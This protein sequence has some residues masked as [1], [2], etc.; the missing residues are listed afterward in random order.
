MTLELSCICSGN[1]ARHRADDFMSIKFAVLQQQLL[2]TPTERMR[3]QNLK[4]KPHAASCTV[5]LQALQN[6]KNFSS[7]IVTLLLSGDS[8]S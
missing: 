7:Q 8:K 2:E 6:K 4:K 5:Y 3:S 1:N